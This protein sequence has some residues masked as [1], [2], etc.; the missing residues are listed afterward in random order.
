MRIVGPELKNYA[1][2]RVD[3]LGQWL[4]ATGGPQ[5]EAWFGALQSGSDPDGDEH[6]LLVKILA[7][8]NPLSIQV[9]P[10]SHV[11]AELNRDPVRGRLLA[12]DAE[13]NELIY[14]L[15][16]FT[17]LA[18]FRSGSTVEDLMSA[19]GLPGVAASAALDDWQDVIRRLLRLTDAALESALSRLSDVMHLRSTAQERSAIELARA[20]YPRDR[21]VLVAL[22]LQVHELL[23]GEALYVPAGVVHSYVNG[24]GVEVMTTSDNVLRLGLTPKR[25][26]VEEALMSV[27]RLQPTA[28][29]FGH[30]SR[31]ELATSPFWLEVVD[32]GGGALA[33]PSGFTTVLAV[34]GAARVQGV[35]G[36]VELAA[37]RA[38]LIGPL[39]GPV[40]I[41]SRGEAFVAG[42]VRGS[43]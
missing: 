36:E 27:R 16:P 31:F 13:K 22:C 43:D 3:G 15:E 34:D 25:L 30:H 35:Q 11:V 33:V 12:D 37:G 7:A 6:P 39:D 5:A 1:W 9:H 2:G 38:A 8:G 4:P 14:A 41:E 28:F 24:L 23:P 42:L 26:A 20:W 21:G 29:K 10:P 32:T 18:G 19:L 40:T 17:A